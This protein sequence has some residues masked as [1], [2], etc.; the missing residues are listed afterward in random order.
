MA[1]AT[2]ARV[3]GWNWYSTEEILALDEITPTQMVLAIGPNFAIDCASV[4]PDEGDY[5][6]AQAREPHG[7]NMRLVPFTLAS[8]SSVRR[9]STILCSISSHL[10]MTHIRFVSQRQTHPY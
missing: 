1:S 10:L 3:S 7:I 6:R 2:D 4:H 9:V 8:L 5:G